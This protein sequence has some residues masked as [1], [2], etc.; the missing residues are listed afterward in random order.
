ADS[1]RRKLVD[2]G[3]DHKWSVVREKIFS[4]QP[5]KLDIAD[6]VAAP[7]HGLR[8]H[9]PRKADARSPVM[10]IGMDQRPVVE[11]AA[12]SIDHLLRN[13]IEIGEP[14]VALVLRRRELVADTQI[15]RQLVRSF[16]I[17]L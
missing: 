11:T 6:A 12:R 8:S 14:V 13:G 1:L 4:A 16:E 7:D 9:L 15:Q 3:I 10:R 5:V 2:Y 17:V